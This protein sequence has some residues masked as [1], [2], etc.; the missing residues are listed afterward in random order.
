MRAPRDLVLL[1]RVALGA[2]D[3]RVDARL[4][5][6]AVA[7]GVAPLLSRRGAATSSAEA[8]AVL[9]RAGRECLAQ[10]LVV[11]R[12]LAALAD[13]LAARGV[14]VLLLKGTALWRGVY[15][16]PA[17]RPMSDIDVLVPAARWR[18]AVAAAGAAVA[19]RPDRPLT[20]RFD[21]A[22]AV[23]VEPGVIVEIHRWLCPRGWFAI[24]HQALFARARRDPDGLLV[25]EATDL[26]LMLAVHAAKHG[27]VVPLRALVDALLLARTG[28]VA[29]DALRARARAWRA[30]RALATWLELLVRHGL[31]GPLAAVGASGRLVRG[32]ARGAPLTDA[33]PS[34]TGW[35]RALRIALT[36]E[37]LRGGGYLLSRAAFRLADAL[38]HG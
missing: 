15:R 30:S 23:R 17:E 10:G 2:S 18:E 28:A 19:G 35:R 32:L 36:L 6:L 38:A 25:P 20:N 22:A 14:P 34:G 16:D 33:E 11:A 1:A 12:A 29:G 3:A 9:A 13:R 26:F 37:G 7:E 27:F 21:Y 8:A 31:E 4:A 24:D 5:A